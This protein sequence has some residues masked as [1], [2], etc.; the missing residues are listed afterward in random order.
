MSTTNYLFRTSNTSVDFSN[1]TITLYKSAISDTDVIVDPEV[2]QMTDFKIIYTPLGKRYQCCRC[3]HIAKEEVNILTHFRVE[4]SIGKKFRCNFCE[5]QSLEFDELK[6]HLQT[7][8]GRSVYACTFC[9]YATPVKIL[10]TRHM[11]CEHNI[12][13]VEPES[14]PIPDNPLFKCYKC[15][16][17]HMD[18]LVVKEH[19]Q[20]HY[21]NT[22]RNKLVLTGKEKEFLGNTSKCERYNC[23]D[24]GSLLISA[25]EGGSQT[26]KNITVFHCNK[27]DYK[28]FDEHVIKIHSQK[29]LLP[30]MPQNESLKTVEKEPPRKRT[31]YSCNDCTYQTSDETSI[32]Q[33]ILIHSNGGNYNDSSNL[34]QST[35]EA[36]VLKKKKKTIFKCNK[37]LYLATEEAEIKRHVRK[38]VQNDLLASRTPILPKPA[39]KEGIC[40][41]SFQCND[42]SFKTPDE[43]IIKRHIETHLSDYNIPTEVESEPIAT[44]PI[45]E[46]RED[47]DSA[48]DLEKL[49]TS[50]DASTDSTEPPPLSLIPGKVIK[51]NEVL[52]ICE[53]CQFIGSDEINFKEHVLLHTE[54]DISSSQ[55]EV[56]SSS[57]NEIHAEQVSTTEDKQSSVDNEVVEENQVTST[58]SN[59]PEKVEEPAN[60]ETID[61]TPTS[62]N[63]ENKVE[64]VPLK[65]SKR[66][67]LIGVKTDLNRDENADAKGAPLQDGYEMGT[68][69]KGRRN[70]YKCK[71]C[72]YTIKDWDYMQKHVMIHKTNKYS[73]CDICG[74]VSKVLYFHMKSHR[75]NLAEDKKE[76]KCTICN[77]SCESDVNLSSHMKTHSNKKVF[78]CE[79]CEFV[80]LTALRL[81]KHAE[82]HLTPQTYACVFCNYTTTDKSVYFYHTQNHSDERS[83]KCNDCNFSSMRMAVLL[84]HQKSHVRQSAKRK[85]SQSNSSGG[86]KKSKKK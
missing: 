84:T 20:T 83:H 35:D 45:I 59:E 21:I 24:G 76:F 27:C 77:F 48:L 47:Q 86:T 79:N 68:D 28:S 5:F 56:D 17:T 12:Q 67:F 40:L 69:K 2:S 53:K 3:E 61:S 74:Y 66:L 71:L 73:K 14:E 34:N 31:L 54:A 62:K 10:L 52:F 8:S 6:C 41:A 16:F 7:H 57:A 80:A 82:S 49:A 60:S 58:E 50:Q 1:N 37:C 30:P 19:S 11:K 65:R 55:A 22:S 33:H 78:K 23:N 72:P 44:E 13:I 38:H 18:E 51:K 85:E 75:K 43:S 15:E 46:I 39:P 42:C 25:L 63:P 29:H 64:S 70:T 4:H 81:K 26:F 36:G 9:D 32:K